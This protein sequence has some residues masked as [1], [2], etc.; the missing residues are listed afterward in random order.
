MIIVRKRGKEWRNS[1][2]KR[3][4][5]KIPHN[6]K[7]KTDNNNKKLRNHKITNCCKKINLY[8]KNK[9]NQMT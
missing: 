2:Y 8:N 7:M 5:L 9:P 3:G 4:K 1:R 6:V